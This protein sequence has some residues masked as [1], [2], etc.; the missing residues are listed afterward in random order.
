MTTT[1]KKGARGPARRLLLALP[2]TPEP[3]SPAGRALKALAEAARGRAQL[4]V[5]AG[6]PSARELRA[7]GGGLAAAGAS[8]ETL[9]AALACAARQASY[10]AVL[11]FDHPDTRAALRQLGDFCSH[12]PV[13]LVAVDPE[14]TARAG[15][16]ASR[17]LWVT[18]VWRADGAGSAGLSDVVTRRVR[19]PGVL[20]PR[21]FASALAELEARKASGRGPAAQSAPPG[22]ASIV[23]PTW[24]GLKYTREC[25]DSVLKRTREPFEVVVVDNGSTDGTA[26]YVRSLKDPRVRLIAHEKNLGFARAINAGTAK[27]RGRWVVWLNSD[28]VVTPGWLDRLVACAERAPWVGAVGPYTNEI[29]GLQRFERSVYRGLSDLPLFSE[30]LALRNA[31]QARWAHRLTGFCLLVKREALARVGSLDESFGLGTYEDFDFCL[32]LRLAGYQLLLA[33]DVFVHHHGH[34]TF[35]ANGVALDRLNAVNRDAFVEKWCR[36]ALNFL[37]ELD[38]HITAP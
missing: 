22:L 4:R 25:L 13:V 34:K 11:A 36:R 16:G 21:A 24:N 38:P 31:G 6:A 9:T 33:E 28:A 17:P 5:C 15:S 2:Q 12:A 7:F 29:N 35:E 30:S 23:V 20:S 18:E 32:R 27:A 1:K 3:A 37:D 8:A 14:W 19:P 10:S 26:A